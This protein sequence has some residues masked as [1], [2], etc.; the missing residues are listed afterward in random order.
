MSM[1]P[2]TQVSC[3]PLQPGVNE[4]TFCF[5]KPVKYLISVNK[6]VLLSI[7]NYKFLDDLK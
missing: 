5:H 6:L 1:V 3:L 7:L 2:Y 4:K